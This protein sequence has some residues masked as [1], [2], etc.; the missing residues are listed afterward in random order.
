[1]N[2]SFGERLRLARKR[3][4]V[5]LREL[6]EKVDGL[7]SAQA[8]S[9]YERGEMLPGAGV[10]SQLCKVLDIDFNFLTT[11][12]VRL[13]KVSF[14]KSYTG[15][16]D[17]SKI[18]SEVIEEVTRYIEIEDILGVLSK[19]PKII[20]QNLPSTLSQSENFKIIPP[21]DLAKKLRELWEI[22]KNPIPNLT[23]L[24]EEKGFKIILIDL[25]LK[26]SGLTSTVT[27]EKGEEFSVIIVNKVDSLERRRFTIA[28]ELCHIIVDTLGIQ[29]PDEF[30]DI[31]NFCNRFAGVF[32]VDAEHLKNELGDSRTSIGYMELIEI[33][34]Y[35]RVSAAALLMRLSQTGIITEATKS[36]LFN[37]VANSWLTK[38]PDPLEDEM[39]SKL[40][41]PKRFER[42]VYRAL[43]ED[44][45]SLHK[46]STLLRTNVNQVLKKLKGPSRKL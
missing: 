24:L 11:P 26:I 16:K 37:S 19:S 9:K 29:V 36:Y 39:K 34:K 38:E 17:L 42:L 8:L 21:D 14:R 4:G 15:K 41:M 22:G 3:S 20:F 46:A 23:E 35:Y 2:S 31:E 1:M 40:E 28:H 5:S 43:S 44:M 7:V 30:S 45:T 13:G 27:T 25:P 12:A 32:L 33:K 10:L 18:E 6:S